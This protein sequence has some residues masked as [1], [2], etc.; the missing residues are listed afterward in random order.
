MASITQ[1]GPYQYQ[2]IV[3]RK[4]F[5]S[6]TKT[7]ETLGD[8]EAWA[9]DLEAKMHRGHFHDNCLARTTTVDACL[10]RYATEVTPE[11]R[12]R[13]RRL[14]KSMTFADTLSPL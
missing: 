10:A 2:A 5:K 4:G 8:A 7:F 11:K 12:G 14:Q 3:R 9:K 1:R 6:Q 13:P